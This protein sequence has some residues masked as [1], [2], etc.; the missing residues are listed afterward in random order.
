MVISKNEAFDLVYKNINDKV[1]ELT[2]LPPLNKIYEKSP[3]YF[4]IPGGGWHTAKRESM[5]DFSKLS[6]DMLREKGFAVAAI[7]YRTA[8]EQIKI[9]D[10]IGDCF[11]AMG[12]LAEHS[13]SLEIDVQKIAVSG[14]SAGAHL[15]LMLAYADGNRFTKQYDFNKISAKIKV[16]ALL[17]PATVLY[18]EEYGKTIGFGISYLFKNPDDLDERK[19]AS[20]IE[21]VSDLSPSTILFA[22]TS[23]PL[24]YPKSSEILYD[25]LNLYKVNCKMVLSENAG[26]SFEKLSEDNEPSVSFEQIQKMLV[27]FVV[28]NI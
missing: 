18:E 7:D 12:Y 14:H 5:I 28:E 17:S 26:H 15:A 27:E 20:P 11:D 21:Y 1:L 16:A 13:E 10:I 9:C 3:V 23:D 24:I 25:K 4:L 8:N 22:G 19:K 2:F 6:V